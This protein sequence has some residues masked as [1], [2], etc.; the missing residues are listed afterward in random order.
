MTK[1]QEQSVAWRKSVR[2]NGGNCVE[3]AFPQG[4]VLVR[5]SKDPEG[6]WIHFSLV[7]WNA[8]LVELRD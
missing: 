3:V 1:F 8:F 7:E 4:C 5:D 6:G 2:S